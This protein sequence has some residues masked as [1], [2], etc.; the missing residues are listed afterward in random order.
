MDK[1]ELEQQLS[2]LKTQLTQAATDSVK[3]EVK[4]QIKTVEKQIEEIKGLKGSIDSVDAEVKKIAEWQVSKDEA[5]KKNQEALDQILTWQKE[6]RTNMKAEAKTF[7]EAFAEE[8]EKNFD[9]I[10]QVKKGKPFVMEVKTVGNMTLSANLTGDSVVSYSDRQAILPA[11]KINFRDLI[12]TQNSPTGTYAH[13]KESAGEGSVSAQTEG[14][15]KTQIDFDLSEVKTVNEY[16]AAFTRFS[17]Q[18]AK[19]L[20]FFQGTLPRLL[21]REFYKAEN[22]KFWSDIVGTSGIATAVGSETE[23]VKTLID[24][25]AYQRNADYEASYVLVNHIQLARLNKLLYTTGNYQ[26]SGGALGMSNG[27][28]TISGVPVVAASWATDDKGLI[29]DRDY[30]ERVEVESVRVEFF[31]QDADN[32]TKNLITARIECYEKVNPM[33]PASIR[34]FDFG[35]AS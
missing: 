20:P 24:A 27:V 33:L 26:G 22:A 14:A 28:I 1:K 30:I 2:E 34:Y 23:D 32:V 4:E 9:S 7:G 18:F 11:Q 3:A 19:S 8:A 10:C 17:K 5:D 25:I 15:S 13:F 29:I 12:P 16:V 35:N 6:S 21:L 31:E